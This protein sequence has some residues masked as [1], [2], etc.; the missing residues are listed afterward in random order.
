ME[1]HGSM[2]CCDTDLKTLRSNAQL[3]LRVKLYHYDLKHFRTDS[4]ASERLS[5]THQPYFM[6]ECY[7]DEDERK[8]LLRFPTTSGLPLRELLDEMQRTKGGESAVICSSHDLAP[9]IEKVF[10]LRKG[11]EVEKRFIEEWKVF[12][13]SFKGGV[14]RVEPLCGS[15]RFPEGNPTMNV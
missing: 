3:W 2:I 8:F 14:K 11:Y 6:S 7:F 5:N 12:R 9:I 13:K 1:G 15:E 4:V 10:G